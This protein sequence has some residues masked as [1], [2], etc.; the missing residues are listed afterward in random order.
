M[1][2]KNTHPC[3]ISN[4]GQ[5]HWPTQIIEDMLRKNKD[6][7][8][9]KQ[10][11]GMTT[12]KTCFL[13]GKVIPTHNVIMLCLLGQMSRHI[14]AKNHSENEPKPHCFSKYAN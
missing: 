5:W 2:C 1:H 3:A 12:Y 9:K 7:Y 11:C 8:K 14:P 10:T 13:F 4:P 6:F